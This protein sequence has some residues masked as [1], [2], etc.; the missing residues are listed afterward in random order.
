MIGGVPLLRVRV[1]L[2]VMA[3]PQGLPA[4]TAAVA[5]AAEKLAAAVV[6]SA[7]PAPRPGMG[8]D[9]ERVAVSVPAGHSAKSPQPCVAA[10]A[11]FLQNALGARHA[12]SIQAPVAALAA[13]VAAGPQ[14]EWAAWPVVLPVLV[15]DLA[16]AAAPAADKPAAEP[17][18]WCTG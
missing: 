11:S 14:A 10:V 15:S 6:G 16:A 5:A 13:A 4:V 8:Q 12:L 2:L 7:V 9:S 17:S 18:V 3:G 1:L